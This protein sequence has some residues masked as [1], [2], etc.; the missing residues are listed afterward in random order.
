MKLGLEKS[1]SEEGSVAHP[2]MLLSKIGETIE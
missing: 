2:R 1:C